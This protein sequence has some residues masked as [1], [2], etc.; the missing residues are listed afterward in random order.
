MRSEHWQKCTDIF[1]SVLDQP[2]DE[3]AALLQQRCG[4][5][6]TLR[7]NVELLLKYH[8]QSGGFI[9]SPA[10]E[11]APELLVGDADALLGRQF[12]HYRIESVLG[13]GGMG[14]VYLAHDDR[15]GR[16]VGL[17]LLPPSLVA[18]AARLERLEREART[19]SALNH[20]NIVT[21]HDI[22]EV[23]GTH[24]IAT[25]FIDGITLRERITR[26]PLP[27][28]EALDIA[29]QI[30]SALCVAHAAGIVHRDIKP[31]NI[32]LRSDGYVK[33]LDFGIAK[34]TQQVTVGAPA[35]VALQLTTNPGM[36]LGTT[37][38]MSP[39]Q[40][41]SQPV[42]GRSDVWSLGVVLYEMLAGHA[43]FEGKTPT[44]I[45][46]AV[47]MKEPIPLAQHA[48]ALPAKFQRVV[49]KALQKEKDARYQSASELLDDLRQVKQELDL[50]G[51][52][53]TLSHSGVTSPR[54]FFA[55]LKRRNVY[56]VAVAYG[57]V[58][59]LLIQIATQVFPFYEIPNWGVRLVIG[60]LILGFPV[61]LV[62][63][64]AFE[65]APGSQ[66]RR[67][68]VWG[69]TATA[70]VAVV[71]LLFQLMRPHRIAISARPNTSVALPPEEAIPAKSIA[72]LPF[73]NRSEDKDN[74]YFADGI[75]DEILARLSK[76]GDLKVISRS[77]TVNYKSVPENLAEIAKQLGVTHIVEGSVQKSGDVVRV[78]VQLIKAANASQIWAETFDRKLTD[79]FG[80]ESEVA[81]AIAAQLQAK[82]TGREEQVIAAIPTDN[83]QAYDAYL[84][85]LAFSLKTIDTPANSLGAQK[86]L[87][88]AVRLDPKFALAWALLSFVEARSYLHQTLQP[89]AALREESRQAAE[90]ALTLQPNLGE[91]MLAK[92]Q[93]HY[94]CL[95]DYDTAVRYF[96]QARQL[97]P[98][99]S[100]I[101]ESLA[102][103]ARRRGQWE[104][105][106]SF[107]NEAERLDPRNIYML[108]QHALSYSTLRRFPEALRKL[109]QVLNITPDD[110]DTLVL[111]AGI[112]QAE[113][114]LSRASALLAPLHPPAD[115]SS[116]WETQVYQA[117]LEH[118]PAP[119]IAPLKEILA[120]PNP[121]LG[122]VN[123]ELRFWLGWAQEAFRRSRGRPGKLATGAQRT[124]T[125]SKRT[126]RQLSSSWRSR[127][128]RHGTG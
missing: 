123:G 60:V 9:E 107:F 48:F 64:W 127:V 39:E 62:L 46:A 83:P 109:D 22:G 35:S 51:R 126:A 40:A 65:L 13:V 4:G 72:V 15:L 43:P 61:A 57:V 1:N 23:D 117:I 24:Y 45:M 19:A 70:A 86:Y 99:S 63:A 21:I 25:E 110:L 125:F 77:S 26:G 66:I 94:A 31:E 78:N 55:E 91:A 96:E 33:V 38:Y 74:A 12:G 89:T 114:D 75:Q 90:T 29:S 44:D 20:P 6:E 121:A 71:L 11:I 85:G 17:K 49:D 52:R 27:P 34:F 112:A 106:E 81:K 37:R 108:T 68:W 69:L 18:D 100:R 73:E 67:K 36:I 105:S 10:F 50:P 92:G 111:K 30:A 104:R 95:K 53:D 76:I 32:M 116:A 47:L 2:P 56:R 79:I 42:D 98:N 122:F 82:I 3:R 5:D 93:Y 8:E 41:R 80:V 59:W 119:I 101:P 97:L 102:F 58:G 7:R 54:N 84:R 128:D 103:V 16:K 28:N 88:E 118:R 120:K 124:G 14:V 87:R 115:N 113:G